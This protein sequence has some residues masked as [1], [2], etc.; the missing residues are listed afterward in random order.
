MNTLKNRI[1]KE[2]KE[3]IEKENADIKALEDKI[4]TEMFV[5]S[6]NTTGAL[7]A[8]A[9]NACDKRADIA[10]AQIKAIQPGLAWKK[11]IL[12]KYK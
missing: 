4:S 3:A 10:R 2:L 7:A 5:K 8:A 9:R 1:V 11:E 12:A 6:A